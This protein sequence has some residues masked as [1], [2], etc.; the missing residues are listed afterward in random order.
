MIE[1]KRN[2]TK[3]L[4]LIT[5]SA[6]TNVNISLIHTLDSSTILAAT[7]AVADDTTN[8][9]YDLTSDLTDAC[10]IVKII[11]KYDISSVTKTKID[12]FKVFQPYASSA[13][14]ELEYPEL[15]SKLDN[16]DSIERK[17]RAVIDTYCG[18]TFDYYP[19]RAI[20]L[21]GSGSDTL[22]VY[23]RVDSLSTVTRNSDGLDIT[24][25]CE[26][27]PESE[28]YIRKKRTF[29]GVIDGAKEIVVFDDG[30]SAILNS[31]FFHKR[32]TYTLNGDFGWPYI[33]SNV[34]E[35]AKLLIADYLNQDSDYRRH[36]VIFQGTGPVQTN[37]KS[38]LIGTTG[39][40]DADV[41]LIDY[42]M[43]I[44]DSI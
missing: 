4:T 6:A 44:M 8:F 41:L 22:H 42:T 18:Q 10:G 39:N 20:T 15:A 24:G 21:D 34:N 17:I 7:A 36:N 1:I 31:K 33:P 11:W 5:P 38:D 27:A 13:D 3:T 28:F 9:H 43:F 30:Y 26:V 2:K 23:Y 19:T 12:Y 35:A 29:D 16:F 32:G 14:V 40:V 25:Y 37:F